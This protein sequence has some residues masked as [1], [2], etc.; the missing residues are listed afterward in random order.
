MEKLIPIAIIAAIIIAFIG[1]TLPGEISFGGYTA[2]DWEAADDLIA[3]DDLTVAGLATIG[4]TL[5][6]TGETN[7]D[8]LIE[9]GDVTAIATD[10][11]YSL[12]AAQVCDS[13]VITMTSSAT[14][15]INV[16]LPATTTLYAD[17][18]ATNGD[19]KTLLFANLSAAAGTTT[20]MVAGAGMTLLEPDG[21]DVVIAGG[22]SWV[23]V[24]LHRY[25]S[26]IVTAI[27]D[28]VID[29]D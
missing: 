29:A 5:T 12:T 16:T 4:E 6:V 15:N 19:S 18:L 10:T 14:S 27:I 1:W 28:E 21:Q 26:N 23:L 20:T 8:T 24:T 3:G 11:A 17:C 2:G 22:T 13:S 7:L 25:T 9:G